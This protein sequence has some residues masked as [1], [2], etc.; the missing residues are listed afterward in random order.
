MTSVPSGRTIVARRASESPPDDSRMRS[1]SPSSWSRSV[2][3]S[4]APSS[5]KPTARSWLPTT[6]V[7]RAPP[8][9]P[10]WTA[11]RPT[12]PAAPVTSTLR[13]RMAGP[14]RRIR[15]AVSPATGSAAAWVN[16]VPAGSSASQAPGTATRSAQLP[17]PRTPTTRLPAGGPDGAATL[18]VPARSHPGR[19]PSAAARSRHTSPRLIEIAWTSTSAWSGPGSGSGRLATVT[20]PGAVRSATRARMTTIKAVK[21]A[22]WV[23]KPCRRWVRSMR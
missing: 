18:T 6:A 4:V 17:P 2:T 13:P 7:T 12:P 3:T 14:S 23:M 21:C 15:S 16:E 9:L 20:P 5:R 10:S 1:Y 11:K 19:Q 8:S 22:A